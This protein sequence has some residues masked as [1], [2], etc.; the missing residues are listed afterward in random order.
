LLF[1]KS[2]KFKVF[3]AKEYGVIFFFK[4]NDDDKKKKKKKFHTPF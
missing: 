2:K 1:K 4:K 3:S